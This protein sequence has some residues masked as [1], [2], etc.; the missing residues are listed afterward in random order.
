[1]VHGAGR[2]HHTYEQFCYGMHRLFAG[3]KM[4][5]NTD[6]HTKH[7]HLWVVQ[8]TT[9]KLQWPLYLRYLAVRTSAAHGVT[10]A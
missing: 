2:Q 8:Q 10:A 9:A 6:A 4:E 7:R 3:S 1:M 5:Q